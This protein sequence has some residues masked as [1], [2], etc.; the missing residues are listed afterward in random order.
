[1]GNVCRRVRFEMLIATI[2]G[3]SPEIGLGGIVGMAKGF[4]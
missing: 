2:P 4:C 1:M 3:A